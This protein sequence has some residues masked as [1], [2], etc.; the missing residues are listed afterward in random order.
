MLDSIL[1]F[2]A[3]FA[4]AFVSGSAGFGGAL[5]LLPLL[6][7][8]T[9]PVHAVPLLTLAQLVGNGSRVAFNFRQIRWKPVA[10]FLVTA[11]P[12]SVIGALTFVQLPKELVTRCVGGAIILFLLLRAPAEMARRHE[13]TF[14]FVGGGITGFLSG[15][16]GSAGPLGAAVFLALRLNPLAYVASEATTA[17]MIHGVKML[18]YQKFIL[19]DARF[20]GMA[21]IA[22]AGMVLGT[23]A[24]KKVIARLHT[25]TFHKYVRILLFALAGFMILFG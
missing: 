15:L 8:M 23:W 18:V 22:A 2:I 19:F 12:L 5:L 14:L 21:A 25:E 6:V 17:L 16:V 9:G 11:I 4:A 13:N 3:S 20:G 10:L 1:L 7:A 24:A